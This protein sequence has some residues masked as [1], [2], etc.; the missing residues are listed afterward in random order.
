MKDKIITL[1]I[2]Y[3]IAFAIL[4]GLLFIVLTARNYFQEG[5]DLVTKYRYLTDAFTVPGALFILV[6]LLVFLVNQGSL[7]ALGWMVKRLFRSLIPGMRI[8]REQTY[9]E[10]LETRRKVAGYGFL[11]ISG[12][13]FLAI[14]MVFL[15][16][17]Y[18]NYT[19]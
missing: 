15:I 9:S 1:L 19:Y 3:G 5:L 8:Q 2:K 14:G 11:F 7:A 10:Y 17:F 4:V 12:A 6:G 13:I 18:T 16:L